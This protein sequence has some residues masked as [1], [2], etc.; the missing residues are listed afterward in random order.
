MPEIKI[1]SQVADFLVD[2]N[3]GLKRRLL[4][5]PPDTVDP[6]VLENLR[7]QEKYQGLPDALAAAAP[8]LMSPALSKGL[9]APLR[10]LDL[11]T[12][13]EPGK[14]GV[15]QAV[16]PTPTKMLR[17]MAKLQ[18][19]IRSQEITPNTLMHDRINRRDEL[20]HA[21]GRHNMSSILNSGKLLAKSPYGDAPGVSFSRVPEILPKRR[22]L[23]LGLTP[24]A[25]SKVAKRPITDSGFEKT[26]TWNGG[27]NENFE[28]ET[29]T[30][31][32]V[33]V[34][35][36]TTNIYPNLN[37]M[38]YK[39]LENL[40]QSLQPGWNIHPILGNDPRTSKPMAM[41]PRL[42][43]ILLGAE[44][45]GTATVPKYSPK[46][47]N[48]DKWTA[49]TP[50]FGSQ[51]DEA[52]LQATKQKHAEFFK[53]IDEDIK[54]AKFKYLT[55]KKVDLPEDVS[56][57]DFLKS[58]NFANGSFF[59]KPLETIFDSANSMFPKKV[60]KAYDLYKKLWDVL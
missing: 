34:Q 14:E 49:P 9:P 4:E 18:G 6:R 47:P 20:F 8:F 11:L 29:R 28:F 51:I 21:T 48:I 15:M 44:G 3:E 22:E 36:T 25:F 13:G 37:E 52:A 24:E 2:P 26:R 23:R 45:K 41:N 43:E 30:P 53:K 50:T 42:V 5:L 39:E 33:P 54:L 58:P 32:D 19:K 60:T 55:K 12:A 40:V 38:S 31:T 56:V 35:Q 16:V 17:K 1:P 46:P 27:R 10:L 57:L 59:D 7:F